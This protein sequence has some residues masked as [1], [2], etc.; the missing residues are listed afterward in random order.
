MVVRVVT[1]TKTFELVRFMVVLVAVIGMYGGPWSRDRGRGRARIESFT[2]II[3]FANGFE[4]EHRASSP[5][6]N[7]GMKHLIKLS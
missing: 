3:N 1:V 5:A 6:N 2:T 7:T 4:S